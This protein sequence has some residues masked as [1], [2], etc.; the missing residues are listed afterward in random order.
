MMRHGHA[1]ANISFFFFW[2]NALIKLDGQNFII[3]SVFSYIYSVTLAT[4]YNILK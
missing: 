2:K 4:T 3:S 1:M